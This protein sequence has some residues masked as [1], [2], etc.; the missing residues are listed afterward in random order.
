MLQKTESVENYFDLFFPLSLFSSKCLAAQSRAKFRH[1]SIKGASKWLRSSIKQRRKSDR[2]LA[3]FSKST[4]V[5]GS[6]QNLQFIGL[7]SL[8]VSAG[9]LPRKFRANNHGH[10]APVLPV[11]APAFRLCSCVVSLAFNL[12]RV[13]LPF[14]MCRRSLVIA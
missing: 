7:V 1:F 12:P 3:I 8:V 11:V 10:G 4:L 5:S 14:N 2:I 6:L 13:S 9:D